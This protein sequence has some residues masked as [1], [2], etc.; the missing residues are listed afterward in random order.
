MGNYQLIEEITK[1]LYFAHLG[2]TCEWLTEQ[3][4][5]FGY[6]MGHS[7]TDFS[8]YFTP[9]CIKKRLEDL[10]RKKSKKGLKKE[11]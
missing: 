10:I 3:K 6:S 1:K 8:G 4:I 7:S 2:F 9:G 11:K 5:H